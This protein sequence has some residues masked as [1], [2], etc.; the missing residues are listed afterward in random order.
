MIIVSQ[1]RAVVL[2]FDNL[3]LLDGNLEEY[4]NCLVAVVPDGTGMS[5]GKF[6]NAARSQEV[7]DEFRQAYWD[8]KKVF[9]VP[10]D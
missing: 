9:Y 8:G 1:N 4:P 5:I 3:L 2:N 10:K 7:I 6:K